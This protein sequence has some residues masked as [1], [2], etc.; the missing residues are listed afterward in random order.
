MKQLLIETKPLFI[1]PQ[2]LTEAVS[3]SNGG[4]LFVEIL[5]DLGSDSLLYLIELLPDC[6]YLK[7]GLMKLPLP[8]LK[9]SFECLL[10]N[11]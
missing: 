11:L 7:L 1:Q 9:L 10:S 6:F 3:K 4:N 2:S 8:L 5:D